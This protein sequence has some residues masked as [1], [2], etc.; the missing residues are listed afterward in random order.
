MA[1][2]VRT[3]NGVASLG[4][5]A[6][7]CLTQEMWVRADRHMGAPHQKSDQGGHLMN[8][9]NNTGANARAMQTSCRRVVTLMCIGLHRSCA[10]A[11]R[12]MGAGDQALRAT[13]P[14]LHAGASASWLLQATGGT[15]SRRN[16]AYVHACIASLSRGSCQ[17]FRA[18]R[19]RVRGG[20]SAS[21]AGGAGTPARGRVRTN[22][23]RRVERKAW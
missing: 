7:A 8:K 5:M 23:G 13:T 17:A 21:R 4:P 2:P 11:I 22:R 10:E 14:F 12:R 20:A 9:C 18:T 6:S 19:L 15:M 1:L 3:G 16:H